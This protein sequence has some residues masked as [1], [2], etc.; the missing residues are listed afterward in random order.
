VRNF[1]LAT[2]ER[3][4]RQAIKEYGTQALGY[5]PPQGLDAFERTVYIGT[6][7]KS[8]F[9]G[10]RIA[11]MVLPP[12]LVAPMTV[13]RTLL[14]GHSAPIAQLTLA[15]FME[16]GHFGAHVRTMRAMY[17]K[18]RDTLAHLLRQHLA[19][20]LEPHVPV[21]G[22]QMACRLM[23]DLSERDVIHAAQKAGID[24]LGL[25]AL[26]ATSN[27]PEPQQAGVLMGFAAYT[28][29]EMEAAVKKLARV[30]RTLA[31]QVSNTVHQ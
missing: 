17:A 30:L 7:T 1:P 14:D 4:Q 29:W 2:W 23:G 31:R 27:P 21:G 13:T 11:Y 16:G 24:L 10:L 15:R 26:H 12:A 25:T 5:S 20:F 6:C 19:D 3:L 28:P 9:P 8:L 18:R 22:M